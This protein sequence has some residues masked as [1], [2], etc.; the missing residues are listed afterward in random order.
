[1]EIYFSGNAL[2]WCLCDLMFFYLVFPFVVR[3]LLNVKFA[4]CLLVF[5]VMGLFLMPENYVHAFIYINPLFRFVDFYIGIIMYKLYKKLEKKIFHIEY[6]LSIS[7]LVLICSTL[8]YAEIPNRF[9]YQ[10]LFWLSSCLVIISFCLFERKSKLNFDRKVIKISG[11]ISFT[12][13]M[14]HG[15]GISVLGSIF[16]RIGLQ[17]FYLV[18]YI[19]DLLIITSGAYIVNRFYETPIKNFINRKMIK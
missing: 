1:M 2:S 7:I 12:F 17:D 13:Y 15:L 14:I 6:Y 19:L 10:S 11:D 3:K 18:K 8:L 4:V 16:N 5:Y 9:R